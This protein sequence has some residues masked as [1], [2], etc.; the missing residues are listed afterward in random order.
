MKVLS[1]ETNAISLEL[2]DREVVYFRGEMLRGRSFGVP[3]WPPYPFGS[4]IA[5][6][7]HG[8]YLL[9]RAARRDDQ[10]VLQL[11]GPS[12]LGRFQLITIARD[13]RYFVHPRHLAAFAFAPGGGLHTQLSRLASPSCWGIHHPLPVVVHG[14]GAVLVYAENLYVATVTMAAQ[15]EYIPDQIV[16]FDARQPF[17]VRALHPDHSPLSQVINALIDDNRICFAVGAALYVSPINQPQRH[18]WRL[19]LHVLIHLALIPVIIVV[20]KTG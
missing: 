12:G 4:P 17:R 18:R 8:C 10:P 5:R 1:Q 16:A 2:D 20:L 19:I 14:P 11:N 9:N 7:I 3:W 15:A 6:L 13:D